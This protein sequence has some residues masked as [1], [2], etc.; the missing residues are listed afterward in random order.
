VSTGDPKFRS[1]SLGAHAHSLLRRRTLRA[2]ADEFVRGYRDNDL[3]TYASATS[4]QIV[5]AIIPFALFLLGLLGFLG[6]DQVWRRD[7][8]PELRSD[9]SS[10]VF[11]VANQTALK[12]LGSKQLFWTTLG[13]A[14]TVWEISGAVRAVMGALN[15]VYG[16][17]SERPFWS[18]MRR[19]LALAVG[20][21]G[22]LFLAVAIVRFGPVALQEQHFP[23]VLQAVA[24][25]LRWTLAV[26]LLAIAVGLLVRYGTTT[27]QPIPWVTFGSA[28]VIGGWIVMS[29]GFGIY[30]SEIAS[31]DSIFANLA[32]VFVLITYLY[33]STMIFYAGVQLD[34]VVR[35]QV[36]SDSHGP[37]AAASR[38]GTP[39]WRRAPARARSRGGRAGRARG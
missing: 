12:V 1:P 11:T 8:A 15:R 7:I 20:V 14:L 24:F 35:R 33:L 9:V 32:S 39:E 10:A 23:W 34:A 25:V 27:P 38:A 31:Y 37:E 18:R 26:A 5:S 3:L 22:C 21:G 19:S 29:V 4:F 6:L 2:T 13:G 16:A 28:L 30:L 17:E 36:G